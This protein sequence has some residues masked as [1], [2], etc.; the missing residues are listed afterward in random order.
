[1][2]KSPRELC[3]V[4]KTIRFLLRSTIMAV[5]GVFIALS[6]FV[7]PSSDDFGFSHSYRSQS[8]VTCRTM[9]DGVAVNVDFPCH[10]YYSFDNP[11]RPANLFDLAANEYLTFVGR[12]FTNLL[13]FAVQGELAALVGVF[14]VHKI[15][16]ILSL[17]IMLLFFLSAW[18][19]LRRLGYTHG[20][21]SP[22]NLFWGCLGFVVLFLL[23]MPNLASSVYQGSQ[24]LMH[25]VCNALSLV[26]LS[27]L[28]RYAQLPQG[29]KKNACAGMAM[30]VTI[31]VMG[32]SEIIIFWNGTLV[33]LFMATATWTRSPNAR[34]YQIL[35]VLALL[36][37]A[38]VALAPGTLS[39]IGETA[40]EHTPLLVAIKGSF[41]WSMRY[42]LSWCLSPTLWAMS[43]LIVPSAIRVVNNQPWRNNISKKQV[44]AFLLLGAGMVWFSWFLLAGIGRE[45]PM[46]VVN[47]IYF[48][49]LLTW[50]AG[51]HLVIAAFKIQWTGFWTSR[52]FFS[53]L[54]PMVLIASFFIPGSGFLRPANNFLQALHDFNGPLWVY[55]KQQSERLEL[56]QTALDSGASKVGVPPLVEKPESIYYEDILPDRPDNWR[57]RTMGMFYGL[58][59]VYLTSEHTKFP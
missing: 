6:F 27:L 4:N 54:L 13:A 58:E 25:Q 23:H 2:T 51:L 59:T 45:M 19:F 9:T 24:L 41:S 10:R 7:W 48:Y 50:F 28:L 30:V 42:L 1:M 37:A 35:F 21:V 38:S 26:L 5:A 43:L 22:G 20:I 52:I 40:T 36:G 56:I 12:Y 34:F 3:H 33:F 53:R 46:R 29:W 49:F 8:L 47:G 32:A 44:L 57:N 16:P 11:T 55:K 17:A 15:Y 14:N 39:R 31:A 18:N